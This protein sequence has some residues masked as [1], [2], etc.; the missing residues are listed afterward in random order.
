MFETEDQFVTV[1]QA[2]AY[3]SRLV[4]ENKAKPEIVQR[5]LEGEKSPMVEFKGICFHQEQA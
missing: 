5:D 3:L 2:K 4:R 1:S